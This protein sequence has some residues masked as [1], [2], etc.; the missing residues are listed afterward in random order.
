[1]NLSAMNP[2]ADSHPTATALRVASVSYLNAKP[3]L[4]GIEAFDDVTLQLD[5][6]AKLLDRMR[7]YDADVALLPVIDYQRLDDLVVVPSGCIGCDGPTLTVRIFSKTPIEQI[8]SLACDTDSHTSVALAKVILAERYGIAPAFHDL[9]GG[10]GDPDDAMLLIGDKVVCEEPAGFAH[11]LDLGAAWKDLTQLPFVF[12]VWMSRRGTNLRDLP[13]RLA[14]ARIEGL[15]HVDEIV[16]QYAIPRGWPATV[17]LQYMTSYLKY[18]VGEK[19]LEAICR[20]HQLA[21]THGVIQNR[22]ELQ[23][24][25]G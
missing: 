20:F 15:R 10:G 25:S 12:A 24:Y 11:Q 17:A 1:M 8:Q 18:D 23:V 21:Q 9:N 13:E 3:L 14:S 7:R 6:P 19:Q 5:V 2:V 4:W 22:R 16:K